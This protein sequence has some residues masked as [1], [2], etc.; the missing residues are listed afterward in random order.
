MQLG[1]SE[2]FR[3]EKFQKFSIWRIPKIT[4][5]EYSK[6]FQFYKVSYILSVRII[7]TNIKKN[8]NKKNR[9]SSFVFLTFEKLKFRNIGRSTFGCSKCWPAI[10]MLIR[11]IHLVDCPHFIRRFFF[12]FV[13]FFSCKFCSLS[14]LT[15]VYYTRGLPYD[16]SRI[17]KVYDVIIR[18]S[19][20]HRDSRQ[21]YSAY[22]TMHLHVE[23]KRTVCC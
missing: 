8:E 12:I 23:R 14:Y 16:E 7:K 4:D 1:N 17:F 2:N 21:G 5:L 19:H 6:N 10:S 3:F 11:K 15:R 18:D 9:I 13:I 22:R 20:V